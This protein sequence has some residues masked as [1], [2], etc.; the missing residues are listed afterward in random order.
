MS[1]RTFLA[2][3]YAVADGV[4]TTWPFSF[5]GV[6]TGHTSGVTPYLYPEDVKVQEMFTDAAGNKQTVQR[7]GTLNTPNAIT[8][9]GAPVQAGREIRIYRQ[10][11]LRFPLVDY[12]DLQS[13]S[14]HDLDLANRQAVFL[15]QETRDAASA[16][17][18][19]DTQG[20]FNA[21]RRRI[22]NMADG[23]DPNDAVNMS[24]LAFA[25]RSSDIPL[26][27][28][29]PAAQ[30]VGR[31]LSFDAN[32]QPIVQL[33]QTG[34]ALDLESRLI[35]DGA[36]MSGY[37]GRTVQDK[38][39]DIVSIKDAPFLAKM[40]G[41]TD[42]GPALERFCLWL[43]TTGKSG[44]IPAGVLYSATYRMRFDVTLGVFKSFRLFGAGKAQTYIKYGNV[45]PEFAANNTTIT[46][47]EPVL[48]S[49]LGLPG[50]N[51]HPHVELDGF[52]V[53]YS[54][55]VFRG[56]ASIATPAL[57]DI[58]PL[59]NGT[60]W[61]LSSFGDGITCR[62]LHADEIYGNGISV[63]RS[64]Y[65][66]IEN[67]TAFNVSGGNIGGADSSGAFII[68]LSGSQV[69]TTVA[70]CR[71]IN[72][73]VYLT[74]TVGGFTDTSSKGTPCGYIG[75]CVEY[76]TNADDIQ[77]P[78]T[79][80]WVGANTAKP[81]YE[82][83]GCTIRDC[84]VYGYYM[85]VKSESSSPVSIT[86]C[87]AIA[88]WMPFVI[89]GST[90]AVRDCYA[91]R[92]WLDG[93]V[94]PMTGYR[95]VT[96][97][98]THLDY[99][100]NT[101]KAGGV[102]FDGCQSIV[103][104]TP[105]F[106]TNGHNVVFINQRT[107]ILMNGRGFPSLAVGRSS[108]PSRN[109]RLSGTVVLT[110]TAINSNS[111]LGPFDGLEADLVV[112]NKTAAEM[113]LRLE[114]Y[115]GVALDSTISI[116]TEGLVCFGSTGQ[117]GVHVK[118]RA[119]LLDPAVSFKGT[120]DSSRF[121]FLS[122][123][124]GGNVQSTVECHANATVGPRGLAYIN[125][126]DNIVE[127]TATLPDAAGTVQAILAV[128]GAGFTMTR[129]LKTGAIGVPM[130]ATVGAIPDCD[131][132]LV[133][134]ADA[135]LFS[136]S[137]PGGPLLIG[138][139]N[140]PALSTT[141]GDEPNS[142]SRLVNGRAFIAGLRYPFYRPVAGGAEGTVCITS[143]WK[144]QAW[145]ATTTYAVGAIRSTGGRVYTCVLAGTS[146]TGAP[147]HSSGTATDGSVVWA[148]TGTVAVFKTYG[149]IAD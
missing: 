47:Q 70:H 147:T 57:T 4:T 18:M 95:Y 41:V 69:G 30:R 106:S 142:E 64:P 10:T 119:R 51:P 62:N 88:C 61:L 124:T 100:G 3:T 144:A 113:F 74:D 111:P 137:A 20:H 120:G 91:D 72:T 76:S 101:A 138:R 148:Y 66:Y 9:S 143:G 126:T 117:R 19:Y 22:V 50:V 131:I 68:L 25:V 82:S 133:R 28:L 13:V 1:D 87:T 2:T 85:G 65:C 55:Q 59:S 79:G 5:A 121:L 134:C 97:M 40:D 45:S 125:G 116:S 73:R 7:F 103:R 23:I 96:G 43:Q 115:P 44:F 135:P 81:N 146:G 129:L 149:K 34:S 33:P 78:G 63:F 99:T 109:V 128:Q 21:A 140:C 16:N 38:L 114:G 93:R 24:Q 46:K 58:K 14:E 90:G 139:S 35:L 108:E 136:T 12:R 112:E 42:D 36:S 110:G 54:A 48:I 130:L 84:F 92:A 89:S 49:V 37:R 71:S 67:C 8:I 145:A 141:G 15:A 17:L 123:M 29:P 6:N 83:M 94:Q 56:G 102:V 32:G 132:Q 39:D 104:D 127:F 105:A 53:D 80:L 118:H 26:V 60:R 75:I 31:M 11:E 86:S 122:G 27:P 52:S 77:A 98:F 107:L